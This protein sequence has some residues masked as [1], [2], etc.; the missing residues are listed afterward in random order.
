[1]KPEQTRLCDF[2]GYKTPC[3]HLLFS[4]QEFIT[5]SAKVR[6]QSTSIAKKLTHKRPRDFS[7]LAGVFE[8]T[9]TRDPP[10]LHFADKFPAFIPFASYNGSPAPLK[11]K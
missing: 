6:Q 9:G 2:F 3:I 4:E 10:A 8:R 11:E 7:M 1:S 5:L